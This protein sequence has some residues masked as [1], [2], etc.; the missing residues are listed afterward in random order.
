MLFMQTAALA[1]PLCARPSPRGASSLL[2]SWPPLAD[3]RPLSLL[4]RSFAAHLR[5]LSSGSSASA[6]PPPSFST[7][8][9]PF[10]VDLVMPAGLTFLA[11]LPAGASAGAEDALRNDWRSSLASMYAK[12]T[13]LEAAQRDFALQ[14]YEQSLRHGA[15][16]GEVEFAP[17][18]KRTSARG[19]SGLLEDW[20]AQLSQALREPDADMSAEAKKGVYGSYQRHRTL[21]SADVQASIV[22]NELATLLGAMPTSLSVAVA[23]HR[24]GLAVG[25]GVNQVL[26]MPGVKC[27]FGRV[28]RSVLRAQGGGRRELT[29]CVDWRR[30]GLQRWWRQATRT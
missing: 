13:Q 27:G 2:A 5:R 28:R 22:I 16:S 25:E 24:V 21:L 23:A 18:M 1:K 30:G 19:L 17:P 29:L 7:P 9:E 6:L 8:G 11:A 12:Q 3:V 14:T 26:D 10:A 15:A 20:V 4:P